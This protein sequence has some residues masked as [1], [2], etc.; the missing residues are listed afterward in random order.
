MGIW[1]KNPLEEYDNQLGKI[2]QEKL[3]LKQRMEELENLEKNTLEDMKRC[4][5]SDVY[6]RGKKRKIAFRGR[7]IRVFA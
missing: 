3:Q 4:W 7:R 2:H 1:K 6:E 5:S